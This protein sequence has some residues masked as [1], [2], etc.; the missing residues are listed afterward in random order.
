MDRVPMLIEVLSHWFLNLLV[1][2]VISVAIEADVQ[3]IL[4]RT[5]ILL[6]ALPALYHVNCVLGLAGSS[7]AHLVG[8]LGHSVSGF[9]G[10]SVSGFLGG[11]AL[12]CVCGFD[13]S[14]S[15]TPSAVAWPVAILLLFPGT[16]SDEDKCFH[17]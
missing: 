3:G 8:F 14:T 16:F 6:S 4:G 1:F 2:D 17:L 9:L 5:N 10:D 11:S 7:R 12:E 15:L 13:V